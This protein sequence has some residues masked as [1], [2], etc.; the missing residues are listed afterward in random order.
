M[1][2]LFAAHDVAIGN[3]FTTVAARAPAEAFDY[4]RREGVARVICEEKHMGSRCV[5]IVCRSADTTR[6][7]FGVVEKQ[8]G[9]CYTRTGHRF[10]DDPGVEEEVLGK[11]RVALDASNFGEQFQTDWVCLDA[12]LMPWS[13]KAQELL[14]QQYAAVGA[15]GQASLSATV[16]ALEQVASTD[17]TAKSLLDHCKRR[18]EAMN[19][20]VDSY[21][22][23]C[24]PVRSVGDLKL[25]PFHLL[26]TE[27]HV[28]VQHDHLWHM[29]KLAE[30]CKASDGLL[31]ATPYKQVDA[32]DP[33]STAEATR[34][35]EE[36]TDRG[37]EGMV[38]KPF[39]F[40]AR[41]Q[42]GLVQ[43]AIKCRGRDYLRIIYGP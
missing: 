26:A 19:L 17:D 6:Q 22:R 20:Y 1:A 43:P 41:G 7:R 21:R 4:F 38:L 18:L 2:D 9:I 13:A 32:T 11:V 5:V 10:F 36:L 14:K 30:V 3:D 42:R 12:E 8:L 35:W 40:V 15:A 28:H 24:W 29:E 16:A 37:R 34:W 23:Y 39:D 31:L 27:G 33:A 25:A